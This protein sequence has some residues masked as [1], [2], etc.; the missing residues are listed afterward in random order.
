M[1]RVKRTLHIQFTQVLLCSTCLRAGSYCNWNVAR[2]NSLGES[3]QQKTGDGRR[4]IATRIDGSHG[5]NTTLERRS[6]VRAQSLLRFLLSPFPWA[7]I[8]CST[9]VK[10]FIYVHAPK[11]TY[12]RKYVHPNHVEVWCKHPK[13]LFKTPVLIHYTTGP[14]ARMFV[15][16]EV[17]TT[18]FA[19]YTSLGEN[20]QKT[21]TWKRTDH[22]IDAIHLEGTHTAFGYIQVV[23]KHE[24]RFQ[25]D[26]VEAHAAALNRM[27]TLL[28]SN[29]ARGKI[30]ERHFDLEDLCQSQN[31]FVTDTPCYVIA[32]QR[33]S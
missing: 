29:V 11:H 9:S 3:W 25:Y 2:H 6:W 1:H 24:H 5:W 8:S 4:Q 33:P 20:P 7:V 14:L 26:A 16:W 27:R 28:S 18:L 21:N 19:M 22:I 13:H 30:A 10:L 31:C 32:Q 15:F 12:M 17:K 23:S